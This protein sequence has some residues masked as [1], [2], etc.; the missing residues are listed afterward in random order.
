MNRHAI[1]YRC[2]FNQLHI[3]LYILISK[4]SKRYTSSSINNILMCQLLHKLC[5]VNKI[6]FF[7]YIH[8]ELLNVF[9]MCPINTIN[10]NLGD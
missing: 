7:I 4:K 1:P 6:F 3:S 10:M 2:Y 5:I 9:T 8:N